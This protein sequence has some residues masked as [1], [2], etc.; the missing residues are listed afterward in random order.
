MKPENCTYPNCFI[1]K[2]T[3]CQWENAERDIK[4]QKKRKKYHADIEGSRR[5]QNE[6]RRS[7]NIYRDEKGLNKNQRSMYDFILD[8]V[9]EHLYPPAITEIADAVGI[10]TSTV[11]SNLLRIQKAGLIS[12]GKGQRAIQLNGYEL[13]QKGVSNGKTTVD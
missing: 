7:K 6:Y 8:Y 9:K 11:Q 1:C 10:A 3:D 4:A 2:Y 12:L 5:E 13:V